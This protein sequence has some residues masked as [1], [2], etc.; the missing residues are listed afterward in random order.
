MPGRRF[1]LTG[2]GNK[3]HT[4]PMTDELRAILGA[5]MNNPTDQVFTYV[6]QRTRIIHTTRDK[7]AVLRGER[8]PITLSGLNRAWRTYG[9]KGA[10]GIADF[11]FHDLRHTAATRILR[12]TGNLKLV[13]RLLDHEDIATTAK[14][15][16]VDDAD[17]LAAMEAES[18]AHA[19]E[20]AQETGPK[21]G[22]ALRNVH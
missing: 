17:L 4:L 6:G 12:R 13:Q 1:T 2:K 20:L 5:V 8:Y 7:R 11:R 14:Y 15:A 21:A 9:P 16:H 19:A 18:R 10:A 3:R 22:P